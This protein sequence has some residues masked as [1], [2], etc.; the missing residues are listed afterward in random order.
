MFQEV[1]RASFFFG[2]CVEETLP[3]SEVD[4]PVG[5]GVRR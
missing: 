2:L 5:P 1:K 3:E 4:G